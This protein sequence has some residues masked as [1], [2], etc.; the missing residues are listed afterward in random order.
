MPPSTYKA[1]TE[2][3]WRIVAIFGFAAVFFGLATA[4]V[5]G[6]FSGLFFLTIVASCVTIANFRLGVWF[7][8]LLLPLSATSIFPRQMFGITG[9]N[10][11]NLLFA[12]T[13]FALAAE[14]LAHRRLASVPRPYPRMWWGYLIP[15]AI[16][17]VIGTRHIG[18]IPGFVFTRELVHFTSAGGYLRDVL[19]KPIT[20]LLL[21][22][23]VGRAIKGG[24]KPGSIL[25]ALCFSVWLLGAWVLAYIAL[26][27]FSLGDLSGSSAR[28]LLTR[29]GMHANELGMMSAFVLT[30]M[31][32]ALSAASI[33]R[34]QRLLFLITAGCALVLLVLSFSRGGLVAFAAG[35]L[36][37]FI[38]QRRMKVIL[39]SLFAA[40][41]LLPFL[42]AEFY[43]RLGTGLGTGGSQVMHSANDPLTA[44][45]VAGVWIPLLSEVKAH[46]LFGNGL[47]SVAWSMPL[48]TGAMT[49]PSLNPHN[50][51]LKML[52]EVGLIGAVLVLLFFADLWRRFRFAARDAQTPVQMR[53]IFEAAAAAFLGA[54]VAGMSGGD[55]LPHP[56][57]APLW[58]MLGLLL[59]VPA[60]QFKALPGKDGG[61][62]GE[63]RKQHRGKPCAY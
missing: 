2:T 4:F 62:T 17:A 47:L 33:S 52:L 32:F 51:Y 41:F 23:L 7:L 38:T 11:Y 13:L 5:G 8:V 45:R 63:A 44:G 20:Y 15:V 58:I 37:F 49:I 53:W 26:T 46:P 42:P 6:I 29:T 56:A 57:N 35:M 25:T 31:V 54:C 3:D 16:A 40:A 61:D 39:I 59:A 36:V 12:L 28:G 24:M 43:E 18:E 34:I 21:A 60:G 14:Q 27:G 10:P 9:A 50:M 48:R 1:R 22:F 55:Y 30:L 19:V